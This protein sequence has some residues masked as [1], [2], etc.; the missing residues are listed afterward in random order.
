M[1]KKEMIKLSKKFGGF[2]ENNQLYFPSVYLKDQF[3]KE[4]RNQNETT[5]NNKT[6]ISK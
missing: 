2:S 4:M 1:S 5:N 6:D 3:L